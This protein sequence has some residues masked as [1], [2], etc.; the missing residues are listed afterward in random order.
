MNMEMIIL[1]SNGNP[2]ALQFIQEAA[3]V[4]PCRAENGFN[5]MLRHDITGPKLYMLWNDCCDRNTQ[6]AIDIMFSTNIKDI[7]EHINYEG[8]RGYRFPPKPT[9]IIDEREAHIKRLAINF[10]VHSQMPESAIKEAIARR[11]AD[12][13]IEN[14]L[15]SYIKAPSSKPFCLD[16]SASIGVVTN[17]AIGDADNDL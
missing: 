6:Q 11:L 17:D 13:L 3:L 1:L 4:D 15:F 7:I 14:N 2:G 5:R 8:G 12:S 10:T 16:V 9:H